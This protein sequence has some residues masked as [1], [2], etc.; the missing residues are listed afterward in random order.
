MVPLMAR[1]P[2]PI[3]T[4]CIKGTCC[5]CGKIGMPHIWRHRGQDMKGGVIRPSRDNSTI[6]LVI[7]TLGNANTCRIS[8]FMSVT[9]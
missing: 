5:P 1:Y 8:L 7:T 2:S 6:Y 4:R 3:D 9:R